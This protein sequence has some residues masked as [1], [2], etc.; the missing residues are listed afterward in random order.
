MTFRLVVPLGAGLL[1]S[2]A[3]FSAAFSQNHLIR[4][5]QTTA[6]ASVVYIESK[7]CS[8]QSTRGGSGFVFEHA[9]QIVTAHHVVGGCSDITVLFPE[10]SV[11]GSR[12]FAA[13]VRN[14]YPAGDL[15]L[16]TVN[17][18]PP[19]PA[20]QLATPP[21]DTTSIFAGLGYQNREISPDGL[22]VT[23]SPN[24]ETRLSHWLPV[25]AQ[26][27]LTR[28][29]S[30]IDTGRAVLRF[31]A[32]L[33]PGMSGGPIINDTGKVVGIVAGGLRAGT[34]PASWGWPSEWLASLLSSDEPR[35]SA[36]KVAGTFYTL[37]DLTRIRTAA[38]DGR[39]ITCGELEFTYHGRRPYRDIAASSD[40]QPRLAIITQASR[41]EDLDQ[42]QF[43][44]WVHHAS[45]ATA[46]M[47]AGYQLSYENGV[48]VVE[49]G[50]LHQV[51]WAK[52][53]QWNELQQTANNFELSVMSPRVPYPFGWELDP[54][55][56]KIAID[57]FVTSS[58]I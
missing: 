30:R 18:P 46:L 22:P 1:T 11:A 42:L 39:K 3:V 38:Q 27:E 57:N 56:S 25:P 23:F 28:S 15:A 55:L 40:D 50:L 19:T 49:A 17:N 44:V 47:P 41:P 51:L 10:G 31:N 52:N 9:G 33:E 16:L 2:I 26:Q 58:S 14:V 12:L 7:G 13:S 20:L 5:A 35:N 43:D 53:A 29:G 34:V 4:Q 6:L 24:P 54:I 37:A 48:C 32:Q 45:G 8:D 21:P 36:V